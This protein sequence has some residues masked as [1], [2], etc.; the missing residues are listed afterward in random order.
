MLD[1]NKIKDI[2][3]ISKY[4]KAN[5]YLLARRYMMP[6]YSKFFVIE[7]EDEI[8]TLLNTYKNQEQFCMRSDTAIG[9]VS[10]GVKGKNGNRDTIFEYMKEIKQ[11]ENELGTKGVAIIYWNDGKFCSTYETEGSFYL[12]YRTNQELMIDYI[13]KGWDG[14]YLSHGAACHET[15]VVPW[16]DILFLNDDNR[17]QYR[18]KVV[19]QNEYNELRIARISDLVKDK[20]PREEA[21]K[22]IPC[23]YNGMKDEYFRQVVDQVIIPMYDRKDLQRHYKEYIPIAQIENGKVLVPEIILP[24]RLKFKEK[25]KESEGR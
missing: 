7:D 25:G 1:V 13:G 4:G 18:K 22:V 17:M 10:I 14:S 8:Q 3:E 16:D 11:R 19:G 15:Y 21:E 12:D 23:Q 6:T 2:K 24:E 20:M 9:N 5:G